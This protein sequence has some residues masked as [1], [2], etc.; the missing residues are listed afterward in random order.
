MVVLWGWGCVCEACLFFFFFCRLFWCWIV[1]CCGI[2]VLKDYRFTNSFT[3]KSNLGLYCRFLYLSEILWYSIWYSYPLWAVKIFW[4]FF[5]CFSLKFNLH[6]VNNWYH[7]RN[8]ATVLNWGKFSLSIIAY[9]SKICYKDF[10]LSKCIF[11][12]WALISFSYYQN[13]KL[14]R[15]MLKIYFFEFFIIRNFSL[16]C[17]PFA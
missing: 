15:K 11:L 16:L 5:L 2:S 12:F 9:Y 1:T 3:L 10:I 14:L 17:K 4:C 8:P 7:F 6:W 13:H